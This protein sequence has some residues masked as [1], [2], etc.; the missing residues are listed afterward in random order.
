MPTFFLKDG[1]AYD[2]IRKVWEG[3][4]SSGGGLS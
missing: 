1:D 2:D 3:S 4:L